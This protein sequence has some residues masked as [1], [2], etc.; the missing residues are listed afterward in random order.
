MK[1][2]F[3]GVVLVHVDDFLWGDSEDFKTKVM[4]PLK[5]K[6]KVS[7]ESDNCFKYV[8]FEIKQDKKEALVS[9]KEYAKSIKAIAV[10][11]FS[12]DRLFDQ[13]EK[14]LYRGI[15]GQLGWASIMTRPDTSLECCQLNTVQSEPMPT[16][17][18]RTN[19]VLRDFQANDCS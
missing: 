2:N 13:T 7:T 5:K 8:S 15:I 17:L 11:G 9:Q 14:R 4:D 12:G 10:Q 18:K 3:V 19:T 16:D 6:F 1:A